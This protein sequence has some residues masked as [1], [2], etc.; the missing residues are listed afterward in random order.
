MFPI[1]PNSAPAAFYIT[2]GTL[3]PHSA[4]YIERRADTELLQALERGELCYV[5]N[6]RQMGKS[7]LSVRARQ[8]L[9]L[10]GA[11]TAFLD[12]Q[13]FGSSATAEQWYRAILERI[14]HALKLRPLFLAYW[15]DN[16]EL[17]PLARLFGALHDIALEQ[18]PG[19][20]VIFFDEIDVVGDL[21]FKTDEFFGAIRQC[22][23]ARAEDPVFR[24]LTF[25]ILGT[26]APTDLIRDVRLSP[27]NIGTR[28]RLTDFT[29]EE[30]AP[31]AVPLP[32][33]N[34]TLD[35]VLWWTN[36]H[37][38]LTQRLCAELTKSDSSTVD[39]MVARLFFS[40]SDADVDENIK[41]V[42][43]AIL[44]IGGE[45][46]GF[47]QMALLTR[48][49]QIV[50]G[51][52]VP[53]DNA[54]GVCAALRLSGLVTSR[55]G[56]L[57]SR[58]R[59]YSKLFDAAW[60]RDNLPNA[61][62]RRQKA[63]VARARWQIGMVAAAVLLLMGTLTAFALTSRSA[64]LNAKAEAER[65]RT[66]AVSAARAEKTATLAADTERTRAQ[67]QA[68]S[69]LLARNQAQAALKGESA[70]KANALQNARLASQNATQAQQNA[71]QARLSAQQAKRNAIIADGQKARAQA[72]T[73]LAEG[74]SDKAQR[75][76]Y[77]SDA[78][79]A[80]RAM[81]SSLCTLAQSYLDDMGR[82]LKHNPHLEAGYEW[83]YLNEQMHRERREIKPNIGPLWST[84]LSPNGKTLAMAGQN[85]VAGLWDVSTSK[86]IR[87]VPVGKDKVY[88]LAF[89]PDGSRLAGGGIMGILYFWD[90]STGRELSRI[91]CQGKFYAVAFSHD[92]KR[93]VVGGG[94]DAN[95]AY[96]W[97]VE[98][99]KMIAQSG[100]QANPTDSVAFSPDGKEIVT[101]SA[102]SIV[103][104]WDATTGE[105]KQFLQEN[106]FFTASLAFSPV[107][108]RR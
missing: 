62:L 29:P 25:C 88:Y 50:G 53:D 34:R 89:S 30:A 31:L 8:A 60:V 42:R 79:L 15:R 57:Y 81:E 54:D 99:G 67:Q 85:G 6:A 92:G 73:R 76:I 13:K 103:Y 66:K 105:R 7:S 20:L 94:V 51:K 71:A 70:A 26:V 80:Q 49:G 12:L 45:G 44:R 2:G 48:Y 72:Q 35:R 102:S 74:Y 11:K 100:Q 52:R 10:T 68:Q 36:G 19:P 9:E 77:D 101:A 5:L 84:A 90:V 58:N 40:K 23:N 106:N 96:I 39:D 75:L 17:P 63:A 78:N 86:K 46:T 28:I 83:L 93:V 33:G 43:N 24:R 4:S 108:S 47:D 69:A 21:S 98:T 107:F 3:P 27:F 97:D 18:I 65:E 82:L 22:H 41:N 95:R 91:D 37:P 1:E 16:A 32:G 56:F 55:D 104:I 14:G 87:N 64:A 38:Y 59:V 61:E